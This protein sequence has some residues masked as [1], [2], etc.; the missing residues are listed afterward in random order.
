MAG[1]WTRGEEDVVS[2][3]KLFTPQGHYRESNP[4][5][6]YGDDRKIAARK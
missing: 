6:H 3:G 1:R 2:L 5:P 4:K